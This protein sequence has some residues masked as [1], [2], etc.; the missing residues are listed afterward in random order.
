MT[1]RA[2]TQT[3]I[4]NE[5]EC[6][7]AR[8]ASRQL[9]PHLASG[10]PLTLYLGPDA[11]AETLTIPAPALQLLQQILQQMATGHAI[12]LTPL[13]AELT[14]QQAAD[15]LNVSRPYLVGLLEEGKI[16]H[17][18]VG[19]HRRVLSRDVLDYRA[20]FEAQRQEVL[21]ELAKQAQELELGYE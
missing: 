9:A 15:L 1:A 19:S 5:R 13:Q 20:R 14:T 7:L 18:K 4:P 11:A 21:R 2:A 17:R 6:D 3:T 10:E 12:T 8:Q 16:P